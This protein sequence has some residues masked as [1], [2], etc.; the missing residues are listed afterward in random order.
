MTGSGSA[1]FREAATEAEARELVA[2]RQGW[3]AV[4]AAVPA[5]A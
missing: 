1:F 4:A 2:G 3:T 5:W